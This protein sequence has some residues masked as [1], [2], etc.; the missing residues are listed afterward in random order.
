MVFDVH[1]RAHGLAARDVAET[2]DLK[3]IVAW[4]AAGCE[5]LFVSARVVG[6]SQP[7]RIV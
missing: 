3:A 6:G 7:V 1:L 2:L 5:R 4:P